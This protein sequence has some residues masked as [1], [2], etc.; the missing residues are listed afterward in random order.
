MRTII[1]L[2]TRFITFFTPRRFRGLV[3]HETVSFLLIGGLTTLVSLALFA[4]FYYVFGLWVAVAGILSDVLAII[5]AFF[6]NKVLVFESTQWTAKVLVP[7]L[8]KFGL[9]R[10]FT[11]LLSIQALV[12]LVDVLGFNAM[13][14]RF[15]TIVIIQVLGNYALGKWLVFRSR[16][17]KND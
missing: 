14:M 6:P 4:L 9:S 11:L 16:G 12:L 5:F 3:N 2:L 15:L 10:S 17:D 8:I 13:L 7:E 1:D